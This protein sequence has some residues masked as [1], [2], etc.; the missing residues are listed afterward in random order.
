[1][2][3]DG[4]IVISETGSHLIGR[5]AG[6]IDFVHSS[7]IGVYVNR[8]RVLVNRTRAMEVMQGTVRW[9]FGVYGTSVGNG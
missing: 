5:L 9:L 7:S 3:I 2:Y 1:M 6:W 4:V 8:A